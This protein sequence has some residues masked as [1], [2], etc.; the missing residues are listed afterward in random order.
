MWPGEHPR[1]RQRTQKCKQGCTFNVAPAQ[2]WAAITRIGIA[3]GVG[4][5][6]GSTN[7]CLQEIC[8][9]D[10]SSIA[11]VSFKSRG[12]SLTEAVTKLHKEPPKG[13]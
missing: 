1:G 9:A 5:L 13:W 4:T 3:L 6:L 10:L 12:L 11:S 2:E 7:S 8:T